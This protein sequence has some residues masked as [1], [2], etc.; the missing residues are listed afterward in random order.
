MMPHTAHLLTKLLQ[1][2]LEAQEPDA[3]TLET[4]AVVLHLG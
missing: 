2:K 4:E 1:S 3:V